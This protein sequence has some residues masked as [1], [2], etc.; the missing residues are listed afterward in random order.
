MGCGSSSSLGKQYRRDSLPVGP[1]T[2][3]P[4]QLHPKRERQYCLLD[5]GLGVSRGDLCDEPS[6]W[7]RSIRVKKEA[8]KSTVKLA[9][10]SDLQDDAMSE[11]SLS[12][13]DRNRMKNWL[14]GLG[15]PNE[16]E[17]LGLSASVF[18]SSNGSP[19]ASR[20]DSEE[21]LAKMVIVPEDLKVFGRVPE[22]VRLYTRSQLETLEKM[23]RAVSKA[24][25]RIRPPR[26]ES[27]EPQFAASPRIL[28]ES[29][30]TPEPSSGLAA[31]IQM[32]QMAEEPDASLAT[33]M[34]SMLVERSVDTAGA[35]PYYHRESAP[36]TVNN[37]PPI[38]SLPNISFASTH[39]DQLNPIPRTPPQRTPP[40]TP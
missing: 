17:V 16:E 15:T 11:E 39:K 31:I 8:I 38:S 18:S 4:I 6:D 21:I 19:V 40:P 10:I 3:G 23:N 36:G 26:H 7:M 22:P 25:G 34:D 5:K 32:E 30:G 35:T 2:P 12:D 1:L 29:N 27:E 9:V 13:Q 28:S 24:G 37:T 33:V 14:Q 20:A